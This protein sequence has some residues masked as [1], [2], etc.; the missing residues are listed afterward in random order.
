VTFGSCPSS[1]YSYSV[2]VSQSTIS[3]QPPGGAMSLGTLVQMSSMT[4]CL[5][6]AFMM[7]SF[8]CAGRSLG[9]VQVSSKSMICTPA[10][11]L[12][13]VM[14][15]A[16]GTWRLSSKARTTVAQL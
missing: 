9:S 5:N 11:R 15:L 12:D 2:A 14:A 7:D 16:L 10:R 6:H 4:R 8:H 3:L 1:R 13:W